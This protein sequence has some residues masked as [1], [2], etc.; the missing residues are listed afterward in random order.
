LSYTQSF[1]NGAFLPRQ[2]IKLKRTFIVTTS[3]ITSG[4]ELKYRNGLAGF[5]SPGIALPCPQRLG[6]QSGAFN[7]AASGFPSNGKDADATVEC[8]SASLG[9]VWSE[10][11]RQFDTL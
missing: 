10:L 8:S 4:D 6:G 3:P 2:V 7:P 11:T 5:L 1:L 9:S